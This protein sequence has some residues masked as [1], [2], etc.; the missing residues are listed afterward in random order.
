[1][2]SRL[3]DWFCSNIQGSGAFLWAFFRTR[4]MFI[5]WLSQGC[6]HDALE[7]FGEHPDVVCGA[8]TRCT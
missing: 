8:S 5:L 6:C 7:G 1:M 2:D 3:G 4:G